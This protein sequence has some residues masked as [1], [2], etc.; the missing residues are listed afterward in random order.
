MAWKKL[1]CEIA[2]ERQEEGWKTVASF[3]TVGDP[4][5]EAASTDIVLGP[6]PRLSVD[7]LGQ[8]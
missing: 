4:S 1:P 6:I 3:Q 7:V 2:E 8:I 5:W